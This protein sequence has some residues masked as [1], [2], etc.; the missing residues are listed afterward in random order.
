MPRRFLWPALAV[1][2]IAAAAAAA[3]AYRAPLLEAAL[4]IYL[5]RQGYTQANLEVAEFTAE[6]IVIE[7][8]SLGEGAPSAA[9]VTA[10][11][12]LKLFKN[13]DRWRLE[14]ESLRVPVDLTREGGPGVTERLAQ[15]AALLRDYQDWLPILD[16]RDALVTVRGQAG[17]ELALAGDVITRVDW[18]SFGFAVKGRVESEG[19]SATVDFR[20]GGSA[21]LPGMRL[22]A[23]GRS[24]LAKLPWP[25]GVPAPAAGTL[26]FKIESLLPLPTLVE[27]F[28]DAFARFDGTA[29]LDLRL[30]GVSVPERATGIS[31][32]LTLEAEGTPESIRLRLS[33]PA[34]ITAAAL[35]LPEL[36]GLGAAGAALAGVLAREAK[37]TL[38]ADGKAPM[39]TLSRAGDGW[40]QDIR[41]QA[42]LA[43]GK[44]AASA[45]VAA[46]LR[47][48][49]FLRPQ[50]IDSA[51]VE[52]DASKIPLGVAFVEK[53]AWKTTATLAQGNVTAAGPLEV[54]VSRLPGLAENGVSYSG[55]MKVS[56]NLQDLTV[57]QQ[58]QGS[59]AVTGAAS[60]AGVTLDQPPKAAVSS[61]RLL[62]SAEG[63]AID[64]AARPEALSGEIARAHAPSI[65]FAAEPGALE[66]TARIGEKITGALALANAAVKLPAADISVE[67][68]S[69]RLPFAVNADAEPGRLAA[70]IRSLAAPAPFDPIEADF[71][72]TLKKDAFEAAGLMKLAQGK[73]QTPVS[74]R[75]EPAEGRGEMRIGPADFAF[76]PGQ[77]QPRD[78]NPQLTGIAKAEGGL[79]YD[80]RFAYAPDTGITSGGQVGFESFTFETA[81]V[82]IEK[83]S[84]VLDFLDLIAPRTAPGQILTA[85]HVVAGAALDDL[86]VDFSYVT[87]ETGPVVAIDAASAQI[88]E[89][90]LEVPETTVRPAAELNAATIRVKSVSLARLLENLGT[91][92]VTGTGTISGAIPVRFGRAGFA[93]DNGT[94]KAESEGVLHVRL[95]SAKQTLEAQGEAMRLMVQALEDFRYS[96][97][98][99]GLDRAPGADLTLKITLE[100]MNPNV[101]DG[102]P[103][104]FNIS[105]TGD[106]EP[107]LAALKAGQGLTADILEKAVDVAR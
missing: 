18:P 106:I 54:R 47:S 49:L 12:Y 52:L 50:E 96:V 42:E 36:S 89:G 72:V 58:K 64:V 14:I 69:G 80:G 9:R 38:A 11:A 39:I 95:G 70:T 30:D 78:L 6:R 79:H 101:L 45:K 1:L 46:K 67:G 74:A 90:D 48:D 100:G 20:S 92:N 55:A 84:G 61:A 98:E 15:T 43:A 26:T 105:L 82:R 99:I 10:D 88:A 13:E 3:L 86:K 77:L 2:L 53:L 29:K 65:P 16:L 85:E 22:D 27:S 25:A 24:D 57:E 59:L 41:A 44:T 66:L 63:M 34:G 17:R 23:E 21:E 83:L 68:I 35:D 91:D 60:F 97:F 28:G 32:A 37:L 51:D 75:Y 33:A 19:T 107:L 87:D 31:G 71:D 7:S 102:H 73:A 40:A 5:A 104:R 62:R 76:K 8:V 93:V 103:F 4:E 94:L 81:G 56:G